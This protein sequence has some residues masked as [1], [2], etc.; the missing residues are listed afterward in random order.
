MLASGDQRHRCSRP[1]RRQGRHR[2]GGELNEQSRGARRRDQCRPL[3]L[4]VR[5]LPPHR[6]P[7]IAVTRGRVPGSTA[8]RAPARR[9][10]RPRPHGVLAAPAGPHR[11]RP[12]PRRLQSMRMSSIRPSCGDHPDLNYL[13]APS[14]LLL[15]ASRAAH[16]RGGRGCISRASRPSLVDEDR[17]GRVRSWL[18]QGPRLLSAEAGWRP[19]NRRPNGGMG[20][21]AS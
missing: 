7:I 21:W 14:R 1:R 17:A 18:G 6:A 15:V 16:A 3:K 9:A 5:P 10:A 19:P 8:H 20:S 11:D 2:P 12:H 4:S 13:E